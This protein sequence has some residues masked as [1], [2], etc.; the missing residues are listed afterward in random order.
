MGSLLMA[1]WEK[2]SCWLRRLH[3]SLSFFPDSP[4]RCSP[5]SA[6]QTLVSPLTCHCG[7][8]LELFSSSRAQGHCV[9]DGSTLL[10]QVKAAAD[11][12]VLAV[13]QQ[14]DFRSIG[15]ILFLNHLR[16]RL[17]AGISLGVGR[18]FVGTAFTRDRKEQLQREHVQGFGNTG[19][20]SALQ[21]YCGSASTSWT[22]TVTSC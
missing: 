3:V 13:S 7:Q 15:W 4:D 6:V 1:I 10:H 2:H 8:L 18:G 5:G 16:A 22:S 21:K 17:R 19:G 20:V 12:V 11:G 9:D 14:H